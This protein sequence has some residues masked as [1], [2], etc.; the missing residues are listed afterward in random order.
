MCCNLPSK[1]SMFQKISLCDKVGCDYDSCDW[2]DDGWKGD[3]DEPTAYP[4]V[5]PTSD[6]TA[7]PT[8]W[9][10]DGYNVC[11]AQSRDICCN[12]SD[13]RS[14]NDKKLVCDKLNCM[15][16][17][18]GWKRDGYDDDD[19]M[20]AWKNDGYNKDYD[21]KIKNDD[22]NEKDDDK[23]GV[24]YNNVKDR[25]DQQWNN[26]KDKNDGGDDDDM[27]YDHVNDYDDDKCTASERRY[28]CTAAQGK[29]H[30]EV[31]EM[32]LGCNMN[33]VS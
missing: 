7:E 14:F 3:T 5:S 28:C 8:P 33:K 13:S 11:D 17:K 21:D 25:Y 18:C 32:I 10:D 12:Q 29:Q 4:T 26:Y 16:K 23:S 27:D 31:C 24:D 1:F 19:S 22:Y 9:K 2:S 20:P 30:L 6:P 15:Y